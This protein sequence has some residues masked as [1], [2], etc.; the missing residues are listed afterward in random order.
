MTRL[1]MFI[2]KLN[3]YPWRLHF[4]HFFHF[5]TTEALV[6][7]G[8]SDFWPKLNIA[9]TAPNFEYRF[10]L[11]VS[12]TMSCLFLSLYTK[13]VVLNSPAIHANSLFV[14]TVEIKMAGN[15]SLS[16][17]I[18]MQK[19]PW[20]YLAILT[21]DLV[22]NPKIVTQLHAPATCTTLHNRVYPITFSLEEP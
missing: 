14:I 1:K 9:K 7:K 2:S 5:K 8:S 4:W 16:Q 12:Q 17:S 10:A 19:R 13:H 3:R 22:G 18:T 21:S 6:G 11:W 15:W 20:P